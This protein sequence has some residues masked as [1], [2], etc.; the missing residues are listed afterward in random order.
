MFQSCLGISAARAFSVKPSPYS[1]DGFKFVFTQREIVYSTN[2]P[3]G[4][5]ECRGASSIHNT[6]PLKVE[7][8]LNPILNPILKDSTPSHVGDL[9]W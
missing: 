1:E 6:T 8:P 3:Q 4:Y 9:G 2:I 7:Q 5:F